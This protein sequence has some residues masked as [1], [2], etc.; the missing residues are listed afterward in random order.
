M[1][2]LRRAL[3]AVLGVAGATGLI[4]C[5]AGVVGRWAVYAEAVRRVDR[6]F[7]RAGSSLG[8][9][10]EGLTHTR[11]RLR[12][13]RD[14]LDAIHQR[15]ADLA[16]RT[17]TEGISRRAASRKAAAGA[18][19][20]LADA[21]RNLVKATEA[22][23]VVNGLLDVLAEL[24]LG[25]RVGV[26]TDSLQ[27]A[28]DRLEDVIGRSQKLAAT[29]AKALPNPADGASEEALQL[30][31]ALDKVVAAADAGADRMGTA[32]E[33]LQTWHARVTRWLTAIAVAVTILLGWVGLG[34]HSLMVHGYAG[35]RR[36]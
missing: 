25:E 29:L 27:D 33:R 12:L 11:D 10:K 6:T 31:G 3:A 1:R 17:P 23:L 18:G 35:A 36:Q 7:G 32:Q 26:E 20:Q 28:S 16:A 9:V 15:E 24:P 34:Q 13:T 2:I 19:P 14:E 8:D 21:R 22:A 4:L 30:C 5:T